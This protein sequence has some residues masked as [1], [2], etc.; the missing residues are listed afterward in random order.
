MQ[1]YDILHDQ[2]VTTL[3]KNIMSCIHSFHRGNRFESCPVTLLR[4]S[5]LGSPLL[6]K[7]QNPIPGIYIYFSYGYTRTLYNNKYL[8]IKN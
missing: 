3:K 5:S 7:Y 8:K 2:I 6:L 1:I 4:G